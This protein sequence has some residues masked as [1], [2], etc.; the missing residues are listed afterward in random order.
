M[1]VAPIEEFWKSW[2]GLMARLAD[3]AH[4]LTWS[5]VNTGVKEQLAVVEDDYQATTGEPSGLKL[6]WVTMDDEKVCDYCQEQE[7]EYDLT[8]EFLPTMPAHVMCRC[9]WTIEEE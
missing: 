1:S 2:K 3:L 8:D 4:H 6:Y 5:T 9:I 7:G